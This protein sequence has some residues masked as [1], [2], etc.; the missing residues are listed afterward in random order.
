M[1]K[2]TFQPNVPIRMALKYADGKTVEGRF[3]DQEYYTLTDGR[4]MYV[5][6]DVAA[7]INQ[8]ELRPG[9]PLEICKYWSGKKGESPQWDVRRVD[10]LP[11]DRIAAG[12]VTT[13]IDETNLER[14]LRR[15][16][17]E[18]GVTP[19]TNGRAGAMWDRSPRQ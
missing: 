8:L 18:R 2:I 11:K 4:C 13:C 16:L 10:S 14:D 6:P 5:N 12:A 19:P 9:E 3:G 7:K 17:T 1:E 15:S